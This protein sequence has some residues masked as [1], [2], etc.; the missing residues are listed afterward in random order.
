[1][2]LK[3]VRIIDTTTWGGPEAELRSAFLTERPDDE[4][5]YL[6]F[7]NGHEFEVSEV[8]Y[9]KYEDRDYIEV[10]LRSASEQ[11]AIIHYPIDPRTI[12]D[13]WRRCKKAKSNE[14]NTAWVPD[15][16][17]DTMIDYEEE[18]VSN[19]ITRFASYVD[20]AQVKVNES[21]N[22]SILEDAMDKHLNILAFRDEVVKEVEKWVQSKHIGWQEQNPHLAHIHLPMLQAVQAVAATWQRETPMAYSHVSTRVADLIKD[23]SKTHAYETR[24]DKAARLEAEAKAKAEESAGDNS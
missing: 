15:W 13:D 7:W 9:Y 24:W 18:L 3:T 12:A 5:Y 8:S 20:A 10:R 2:T 22:A 17:R 6:V 16:D 1:M 19:V 14:D 21:T 23:L 11:I 4:H